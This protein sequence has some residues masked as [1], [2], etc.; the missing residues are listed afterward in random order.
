M[1]RTIQPREPKTERD[2]WKD[3]RDR[4]RAWLRDLLKDGPLPV[5]LIL[6][7]AKKDDIPERGLRRAKRRLGILAYKRGGRDGRQ[8][9]RWFWATPRKGSAADITP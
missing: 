6:S 4:T 5:T 9:A 7:R 3:R 2:F 8:G 1:H